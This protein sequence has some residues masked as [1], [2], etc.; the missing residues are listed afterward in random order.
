MK[1][2]TLYKGIAIAKDNIGELIKK[3]E[4]GII[5]AYLPEMDKFAVMFEGTAR[6]YTFSETEQEF[7]QKFEINEKMPKELWEK[8][9]IEHEL[10]SYQ[11][12]S[13]KKYLSQTIKS[14]IKVNR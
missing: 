4:E 7:L 1:Q 9:R 11:N 3:G 13:F 12:L 6:W 10:K 2:H 5:T 14:S 8:N